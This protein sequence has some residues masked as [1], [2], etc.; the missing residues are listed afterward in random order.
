ML[1]VSRRRLGASIEVTVPSNAID[2]VHDVAA[3]PAKRALVVFEPGRAGRAALLAAAALAEAGAELSVVTLAPQATP[4]RCCGGGGAGPYNCGV[5]GAAHVE[6]EEAR[7]LM[8]SASKGS[9]FTVLIGH[10]TPPLSE[11]VTEHGVEIVVLPG[12]RLTPRGGYLAKALRRD[13]TAEVRLVR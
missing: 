6:L 11:W 3:T 7:A 10:P 2:C 12:R 1:R 9:A 5:R 13:T 4:S 8:G